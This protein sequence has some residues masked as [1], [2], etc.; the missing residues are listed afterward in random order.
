MHKKNNKT[1]LQIIKLASKLFIEEGY[2]NT[3]ATKICKL[4]NISPGNLTFYFPSKDHLLSVIVNMLFIF[5]NMMMINATNEGTSSLLAYL[6]ELTAMCAACNEDEITRD[7]YKSIYTS[8]LV[9]DLIRKN[10]T[11]KT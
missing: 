7:F 9:L 4:L 2:T 8:E 1:R 6:L 5:Q 10:D 11:I 3:S